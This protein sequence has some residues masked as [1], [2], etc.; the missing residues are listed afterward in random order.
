LQSQVIKAITVDDL[1]M[2][3]THFQGAAVEASRKTI[4]VGF[5]A[6]E[7]LRRQPTASGD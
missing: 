2:L 1:A 6:I 5:K 3:Y 4:A 7:V